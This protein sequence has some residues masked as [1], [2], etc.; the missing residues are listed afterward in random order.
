MRNYW[1]VN[2]AFDF[3]FEQQSPRGLRSSHRNDRNPAVLVRAARPFGVGLM[4]FIKTWSSCAAMARAAERPRRATGANA[5]RA[6]LRRSGNAR[7]R[8]KSLP[9][10][11]PPRSRGSI[12]NAPGSA[13]PR[14]AFRTLRAPTCNRCSPLIGPWHGPR[15]FDP[16]LWTVDNRSAEFRK[17]P[18]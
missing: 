9:K 3:G 10:P 12:N 2:E 1:P 6:A 16:L 4:N 18:T 17:P 7:L 11:P 15:A 14:S 5:W 8:G 13:E